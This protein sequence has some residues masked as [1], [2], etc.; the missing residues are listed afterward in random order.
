[1][2]V[3]SH[4]H[5]ARSFA[6]GVG[7]IRSVRR[8]FE[9]ITRGAQRTVNFVRRHVV[10]A[11]R[12]ARRLGGIQPYVSAGFEQVE[13]AYDVCLDEITRAA[14]GAVDMR[15]CRKMHYMGDLVLLDDLQHSGLVPEI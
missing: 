7:G 5:I 8:C 14:D 11:S 12:P 10:E 3:G 13:G 2:V 4:E 6:G 9:K 1:M 15:F